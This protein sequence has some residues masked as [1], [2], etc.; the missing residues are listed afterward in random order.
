MMQKANTFGAIFDMDGVLID[1]NPYHKKSLKTFAKS[2]GYN[3][4]EQELREKIYGRQNKEWIPNL[5]D[6]EMT[7]EEIDRFAREK[8]LHFQKIFEKDVKSLPGLIDFLKEL[9]GENIPRAIATSA[10]RMNVDFVFRHTDIGNYFGLVLDDS[11]VKRGKPDPEIYL[12]ASE[13][14][15][16]EPGGCVVFEDSL[17]GVEAAQ[18]AGCKVIAVATTH[19]HEEF[20]NVAMI[21]D[22]FSGLSLSDVSRLFE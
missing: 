20:E 21:I 15:G 2:Y 4:N 8:E 9:Q 1:S 22:D 17:S 11:H 3:L 12:K 16:F 18:R 6:R 10:P 14:L 7:F 13:L 5:F 19:S